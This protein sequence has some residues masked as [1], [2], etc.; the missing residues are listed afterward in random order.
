MRR[1]NYFCHRKP[2]SCRGLLWPQNLWYGK[3]RLLSTCLVN[4]S[5]QRLRSISDFREL[6][7]NAWSIDKILWVVL[8]NLTTFH[9]FLITL[10]E[11]SYT[12]NRKTIL[13]ASKP[14]MKYIYVWYNKDFWRISS[15]TNY[16]SNRTKQHFF[17]KHYFHDTFTADGTLGLISFCRCNIIPMALMVLI[18]LL[19]DIKEPYNDV[20]SKWNKNVVDVKISR[21]SQKSQWFHVEIMVEFQYFL[22]VFF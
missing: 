11:Q 18:W 3:Y 5:W 14:A 6:I 19:S 4:N 16:R 10:S 1:K 15:T 17:M 9:C 8:I 12:T 21:I 2:C 7:S 20:S 13:S 22:Y